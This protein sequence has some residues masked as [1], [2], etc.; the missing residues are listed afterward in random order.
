VSAVAEVK[1]ANPRAEVPKTKQRILEATAELFRRYGYNGTGLKQI[2]AAARAPFGSIYHFFPGG[3]QELGAAVV[4]RSGQMYEELV[5]G[6][7]ASDPDPVSSVQAAFAGAATVLEATDYIDAC[8]IATVALEVASNDETLRLATAD[9][10][11][12]WISTGASLFTE[13]GVDADQAEQVTVVVIELLEGAFVLSRAMRSTAPLD[14]AGTAAA[15]IVKAALVNP[16]LE[17]ARPANSE[18]GSP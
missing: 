3:K 8:P 18:G 4:R 15:A 7:L 17:S 14:A 1:A 11:G 9:V 6:M 10:F 12:S 2:V 13:M 5:V 16:P